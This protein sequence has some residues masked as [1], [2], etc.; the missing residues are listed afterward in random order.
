MGCWGFNEDLIELEA[1]IY[2]LK[3]TDTFI[4][5]ANINMYTYV[6]TSKLLLAQHCT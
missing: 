1:K 4:W 6:N 3:K 2:L 5:H